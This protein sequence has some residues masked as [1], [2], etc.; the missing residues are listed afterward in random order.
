MEGGTEFDL[1]AID[2]EDETNKNRLSTGSDKQ[3]NNGWVFHIHDIFLFE[4]HLEICYL[5][6][7]EMLPI[8]KFSRCKIYQ[9]SNWLIVV[10]SL[11][12]YSI[13]TI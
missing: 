9:L 4:N 2:V 1:K 5:S 13:L 7:S 12:C 10:K 11:C 8:N 3:P 6:L